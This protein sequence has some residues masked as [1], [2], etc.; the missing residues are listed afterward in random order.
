MT[1]CCCDTLARS[2][3]NIGWE[4]VLVEDACGSANEKQQ[5]AG[6][7]GFAYAFGEVVKTEQV[8]EELK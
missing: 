2:A 1:D 6:L 5:E 8:L 7:R 3:F 4:T